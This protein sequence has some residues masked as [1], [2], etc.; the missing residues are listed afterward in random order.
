M[1]EIV[2]TEKEKKNSWVLRIKGLF[3]ITEE[4]LL[5]IYF[6][7]DKTP[8]DTSLVTSLAISRGDSGLSLES[9]CSIRPAVKYKITVIFTVNWKF[10]R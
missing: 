9:H 3:L 2:M 10:R 4:D 7:K 6:I 5:S 8:V 1:G